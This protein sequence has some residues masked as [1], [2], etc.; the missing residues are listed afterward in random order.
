MTSTKNTRSARNHITLHI[1]GID[2]VGHTDSI[3]STQY[4]ADIAN[5]AFDTIVDEYFFGREMNAPRVEIVLD[6]GFAQETVALLRTIATEGF[7][8]C[9]FI[10][11]L[12]HTIGYMS[13]KRVKHIV[14]T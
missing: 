3:V 9:H 12:S 6:D 7:H 1:D 5:L 14:Y 2:G 8:L 10:D 11:C 13:T 4:L